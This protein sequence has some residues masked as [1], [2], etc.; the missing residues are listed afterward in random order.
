MLHWGLEKSVAALPERG[1]GGT[2]IYGL[3]RYVRGIGYD[4]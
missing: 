4:I 2:S 3:Y 1:R